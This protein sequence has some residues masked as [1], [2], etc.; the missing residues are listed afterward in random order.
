[1]F[2]LLGQLVYTSFPKVGFQALS[3]A[4]IPLEIRQAFVEQIVYH[5]WD[6]YSP[7]EADYRAVYVYRLAQDQILFGWLYND[8]IDDLGRSHV[9]YFV[10]Y[11]F[12]GELQADQLEAIFTCLATGP[13]TIVDRHTLPDHIDSIAIA[14]HQ[15]YQPARLGIETASLLQSA[16]YVGVQQGKLI[17]LFTSSEG[18]LEFVE[19]PA[20]VKKPQEALNSP[21]D[22]ANLNVAIAH[23]PDSVEAYE[24][25]LLAK[26]RSVPAPTAD[27]K[28]D[29]LRIAG[30]AVLLTALISSGF[31]LLRRAPIATLHPAATQ[32]HSVATQPPLPPLKALSLDKTLTPESGIVWSVILSPDGKTLISGSADSSIRIWNVETGTLRNTL[33]DHLSIVRS[34]ALTPDAKMLISGS[35]DQTIKLWNFETNQLI[36]TLPQGSPVWTVAVSPDQQTLVSGSEDGILKVWN[37]PTGKLLYTIPAHENRI[38]T[39]TISPDG[40]TIATGSLDRTLKLWDTQTGNLLRT[41]TGHSNT[42]RGL[43]FSPDGQTLASASWDTTIK[44]WNW[45]TGDLI[46]TFVGHRDRVVTV[47]FSLDGQTLISGSDDD[48][49]K[50]WSVETGAVM[51]TLADHTDW[52]ITL[53]IDAT[54]L[55][56]SGRDQTIRIWQVR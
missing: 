49:I 47:K 55:I 2:L 25:I 51:Q 10:C 4:A 50:L 52:V 15:S 43:A 34:L 40:K 11:Y 6:S 44:L 29:K 26:A 45:R 5:Y 41:I 46:R 1:M 33:A 54:H 30:V 31:Y 20:I 37:L 23:Q 56:S 17:K 16:C 8:G 7:P 12:A 35:A 3:S 27:Y 48:T 14:N 24:Q 53:A 39:A 36:Q 13:I 42:V 9:P 22:G 18:R 28:V 21:I 19:A 32:P 38:C